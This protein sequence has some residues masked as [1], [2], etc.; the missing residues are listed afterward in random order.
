MGIDSKTTPPAPLGR[1]R[2][3]TDDINEAECML[4]PTWETWQENYVVWGRMVAKKIWADGSRWSNALSAEELQRLSL[5]EIE[6]A[7]QVFWESMRAK[8]RASQKA[9]LEQESK[10]VTR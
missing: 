1:G 7:M 2:F 9:L 8:Y 10:K 3:W 4:R 5:D 6:D